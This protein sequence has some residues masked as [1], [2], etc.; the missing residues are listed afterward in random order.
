MRLYCLGVGRCPKMSSGSVHRCDIQSPG[1]TTRII[2]TAS[3]AAATA[4]L[5]LMRGISIT[6]ATI[7]VCKVWL[8][9]SRVNIYV[10]T[11]V[12]NMC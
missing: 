4:N 9:R 7:T 2:V 12:Y 6:I 3:R 11:A 10:V 5:L 1:T 8:C